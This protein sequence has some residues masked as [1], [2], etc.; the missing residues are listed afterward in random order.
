MNAVTVREMTPG[1]VTAVVEIEKA[2]YTM[3]WSETSFLSEVYNRHCITKV[4]ELSSEIVAYICVKKVADEGH[5]MNLTVHPDYRRQ[6]IAMMLFDS[7]REDLLANGCRFL[8]L[9]V[10]AANNAARTMYEK[11]NFK[12]VGKRKDYYLRPVEDALIMMLELN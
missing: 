8:Y 1:D 10:R 12:V 5:L 6:G 4:A 3:P 7:A 9:E 2:S 11:L